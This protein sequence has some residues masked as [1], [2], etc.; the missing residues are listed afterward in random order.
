[1]EADEAMKKLSVVTVTYNEGQVLKRYA[2]SL[3]KA[4]AEIPS[5][6]WIVDNAS[7]SETKEVLR[8]LKGFKVILNKENEGFGRANNEALRK[9]QSD[10][11]LILN[12]DTEIPPNTIKEMLQYMDDHPEVGL[13][14][15]RVELA[16]GSL[17]RACRRG[18]PTPW[19]SICRMLYLDR[20]FPKTKL[21]GGYNLTYLPEDKIVE[22]DS[23]AGAFML[24]RKK[25]LDQVGLF[26]EKF[27]MYG[28]DIDLCY[29]IKKQ[30]WK[31]IYH[32]GEKIFHHKG[33]SSGIKGHTAK[34]SAATKEH[35]ARMIKHFHE[36]MHIFYNKHYK[37]S[38]PIWLNKLVMIGIN[39]KMYAAL[40]RLRLFGY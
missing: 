22:I 27:F 37:N 38:Y 28:E 21:F 4:L 30:G 32:P 31:I 11:V 1:M 6:T 9:V 7:N 23:V 15:C 36:A 8:G 18:F 26:D 24:T 25:V 34:I 17:D 14:T 13:L 16:D 35:R 3:K 2:Q 33:I 19:R 40:E 29:R 39:I 5:E 20:V 10:Y 12:P